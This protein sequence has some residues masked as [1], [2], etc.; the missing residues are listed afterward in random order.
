LDELENIIYKVINQKS[1]K[2]KK[3][4]RIQDVE[5]NEMKK[6]ELEE[7]NGGLIRDPGLIIGA[8]PPT[9]DIFKPFPVPEGPF[10]FIR[11]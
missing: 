1:A 4:V 5:L 3:F 2:M 10:D 9:P 7:A 11:W 8:M 6:K